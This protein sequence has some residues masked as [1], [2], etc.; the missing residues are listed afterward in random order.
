MS[1]SYRNK[2]ESQQHKSKTPAQ[3][4]SSAGASPR[5]TASTST[6]GKHSSANDDSSGTNHNHKNNNNNN[7][8]INNNND[9]NDN[10][11][12]DTGDVRSGSTGMPLGSLPPPPQTTAAATSASSSASSSAAGGSSNAVSSAY[13]FAVD[14]ADGSTAS[15]L[16]IYKARCAASALNPLA[17]VVSQ[18]APSA[19]GTRSGVS[20]NLGNVGLEMKDLRCLCACLP[21]CLTISS[22][23]LS[24]NVLGDAG[25]QEVANL[26]QQWPSLSS[27][28]M[29][30]CHVSDAGG[31]SI[32]LALGNLN[33][34][35]LDGNDYDGHLPTK[36]SRLVFLDLSSNK[37]ANDFAF[38]F[39]SSLRT[40]R[41]LQTLILSN[42]RIADKGGVA[43]AEVLRD[44]NRTLQRLSLIRNMLGF[45]AGQGFLDM[46]RSNAV[47][48]TLD[49][50]H[51]SITKAQEEAIATGISENIKRHMVHTPRFGTDD[52]KP[53]GPSANRS[54][55]SL[56]HVA[57]PST[58]NAPLSSPRQSIN[59]RQSSNLSSSGSMND[60]F[61]LPPPSS[62]AH[63]PS[64]ASPRHS[65]K[66]VKFDGGASGNSGMGNG[67]GINLNNLEHLFSPQQSVNSGGESNGTEETVIRVHHA[68]LVRR[69]RE[70]L[71]SDLILPENQS[72]SGSSSNGLSVSRSL[73]AHEKVAQ[74]VSLFHAS[75]HRMNEYGAALAVAQEK[76]TSSRAT[77]QLLSDRLRQTSSERA[78]IESSYRARLDELDKAHRSIDDLKSAHETLLEE[79]QQSRSREQQLSSQIKHN[80]DCTVQLAETQKHVA[81]LSH[82]LE[83]SNREMKRISEAFTVQENE[84]LALENAL[85]TLQNEC[86]S[87][88]SFGTEK[89][90]ECRALAV[91]NTSVTAEHSALV[92]ESAREIVQLKTELSRRDQ[93][94]VELQRKGE[95]QRVSLQRAE[96]QCSRFDAELRSMKGVE[97]K[98]R[99][100]EASVKDKSE[101]EQLLES[102]VGELTR[103]TELLLTA[104]AEARRL[105]HDLQNAYAALDS[106]RRERQASDDES[107]RLR[108]ELQVVSEQ[109]SSL[110]GMYSSVSDRVSQL[111]VGHKAVATQLEFWKRRASESEQA[112]GV[113][114]MRWE[115]EHSRAV[116]LEAKYRASEEERQ[117]AEAIRRALHSQMEDLRRDSSS[118]EDRLRSKDRELEEALKL[119]AEF[120]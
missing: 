60:I 120:Q 82:L 35:D 9:N 118:Y 43:L 112:V 31:M 84:R 119:I 68:D 21:F 94:I 34:A 77:V 69:C 79:L 25:A 70:I 113:E 96:A 73:S 23:V 80:D 81:E 7:N 29:E 10:Y 15:F 115:D 16:E 50:S 83:A 91:R 89:E 52:S 24:G 6:N 49:V 101:I 75:V 32:A 47:L 37:L 114:K 116:M 18:L 33:S 78:R 105:R 67:S 30:D 109:L 74:L 100:A 106:E 53:V 11:Y 117:S 48:H 2:F 66:N 111:D 93:V 3:A 13:Q 19:V 65:T 38:A 97:E 42:N 103:N 4:R 72:L 104:E 98:W 51:N 54:S 61:D 14:R 36:G 55:P 5:H 90:R 86:N 56:K 110:Q 62:N 27:L 8:N 63:H 92:D 59:A 28:S 102:T 20:L 64:A 87:L 41:S 88:R 107:R 95:E 22:L 12:V 46:L 44:K 39:S 26:V 99:A 58:G 76:I 40:N 108:S 17:D 57:Q 45:R 85:E 71:E 1:S